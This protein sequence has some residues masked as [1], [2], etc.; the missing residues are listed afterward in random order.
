MAN[1]V[2][3]LSY[4]NTFGEWMVNTNELAG[5]LNTLATGNYTKNSGTLVLNSPQTSLQVSNTALF[6]GNLYMTGTGSRITTPYLY[7]TK[8]AGINELTVEHT[9]TT[10]N[11][12]VTDSLGGTA[13]IRFQENLIETSVAMAI[14]LG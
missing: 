4:A 1:T 10:A 13:L 3:I 6:T 5:E 9:T 14:A 2:Q 7:V 12:V 8:E 11:L